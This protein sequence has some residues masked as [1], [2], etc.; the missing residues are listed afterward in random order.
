MKPIIIL[1]IYYFLYFT[2]SAVV[3]IVNDMSKALDLL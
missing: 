3:V 1:F 2:I